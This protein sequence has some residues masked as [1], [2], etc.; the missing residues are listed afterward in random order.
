MKVLVTGGAGYVGSHC[1]RALLAAKHDVT[2]LDN[3]SAGHA[4]AVPSDARLVVG[5]LEDIDLLE[6]LFSLGRFDAVMHFAAFIE[7]GESVL[8]PLRF[9]ENNVGNSVK[10]LSAMEQHGVKRMVFSSTCATYG[11]PERMPITEDM[12]QRPASPYARAKL[13]VEWALADSAAA[14][15]LGYVALRYFNAAGAAADGTIGEDH[16]PETHLIPNVLM[17]A[18][19]QRPHVKIFGTD[20]PTPDGTCVRDYVHVEDLAAAHLK[21]IEV[22]Q[23][24]EARAYNAGTGQGATVREVV[25]VARKI[26]GHAIPVEESPRREGDVPVLCADSTKIRRELGWVPRFETLEPIVASAWE[27]HR[28]HPRGFDDRPTR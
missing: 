15:G 18:L 5:E 10:L 6:G 2:V 16:H 14:W 22:V 25:E 26:T 23:T 8:H 7:V 1:V 24:G 12:P 28:E 21:A 20:Y 9:Y 17:V 13:A 27:W 3:L 19:G 11:V 4:A